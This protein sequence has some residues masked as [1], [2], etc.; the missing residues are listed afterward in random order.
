MVVKRSRLAHAAWCLWFDESKL[1]SYHTFIARTIDTSY[2]SMD[3]TKNSQVI[4]G[5]ARIRTSA[6]GGVYEF[7]SVISLNKLLHTILLLV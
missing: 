7:S 1:V 4:L 5:D 6:L 2:S 3:R